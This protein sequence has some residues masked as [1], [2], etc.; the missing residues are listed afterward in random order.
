MLKQKKS[1]NILR[2][3]VFLKIFK[4]QESS[5]KVNK[6]LEYPKFF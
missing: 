6:V 1:K 4:L 5:T 3:V 2:G